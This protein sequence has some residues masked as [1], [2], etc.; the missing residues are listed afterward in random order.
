MSGPSAPP[1]ATATS[2]RASY[3]V[4]DDA[5]AFMEA[6]SSS[7]RQRHDSITSV[8]QRFSKLSVDTKAGE[9]TMPKDSSVDTQAPL[10]AH[11][12][13]QSPKSL[14]PPHETEQQEAL[15]QQ[16]TQKASE[17]KEAP[18]AS[19][20]SP[21]EAS[22]KT[23]TP[24]EKPAAAVPV[25]D[26]LDL[27][28]N[29]EVQ[30]VT[31]PNAISSQPLQPQNLVP[32]APTAP[33]AT[34]SILPQ[35]IPSQYRKK[36]RIV[37]RRWLRLMSILRREV[38]KINKLLAKAMDDELREYLTEQ[39]EE[40]EEDIASFWEELQERYED[41]DLK[42]VEEEVQKMDAKMNYETLGKSSANLEHTR[43]ETLDKPLENDSKEQSTPEPVP[44]EPKQEEAPKPAEASGTP[45]A[46]E[47]TPP[48]QSPAAKSEQLS[49]TAS[50]VAPS[51][52]NAA[53]PEFH[54]SKAIPNAPDPSN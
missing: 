44:E 30:T 34:T 36:E 31:L 37:P 17:S 1:V 10:N 22:P 5:D 14:Q 50:S 3:N 20:H 24:P 49:V 6:F 33:S 27:D 25:V 51:T 19:V 32:L 45:T 46:E 13:V 43:Q 35:S 53:A 38:K 2:R 21:E 41:A 18:P 16:P 28:F 42:Q 29:D 39:K 52:V 26:L 23:E 47:D 40:L 48:V 7:T 9:A 12:P 54:P 11:S 15:P 8:S 4:V